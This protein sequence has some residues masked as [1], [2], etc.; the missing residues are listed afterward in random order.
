MGSVV[1]QDHGTIS[2][3]HDDNWFVRRFFRHGWR[4]AELLV[5]LDEVYR[6][7]DPRIGILKVLGYTMEIESETPP[8]DSEHWLEVDLQ[9][10]SLATNSPLVRLAVGKQPPGEETLYPEFLLKQIFS[11]LDRLDFRVELYR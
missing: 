4:A 7:E 1:N 6:A 8:R 10:R 3:R 9:K 5:N 11:V 2:I